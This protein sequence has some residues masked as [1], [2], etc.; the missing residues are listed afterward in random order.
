MHPYQTSISKLSIEKR[1]RQ[2]FSLLISIYGVALPKALSLLLAFLQI[3]LKCSSKLSLLSILTSGIFSEVLFLIKEPPIL[4]HFVTVA[5]KK[6]TFISISFHLVIKKPLKNL[7]A[8]F[9]C[10][11][12]TSSM[13][14]PPQWMMLSSAQLTKSVSSMTKNQSLINN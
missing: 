12:M 2:E 14:S 9:C 7:L 4:I 11:R 13:L 5:L 8:E 6:M 10:D 1:I 3:F